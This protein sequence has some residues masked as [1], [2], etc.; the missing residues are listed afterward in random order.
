MS[1]QAG[2]PLNVTTRSLLLLQHY[3]VNPG[4]GEVATC[5][6]KTDEGADME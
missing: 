4:V 1:K 6:A 2:N 5:H 3:I